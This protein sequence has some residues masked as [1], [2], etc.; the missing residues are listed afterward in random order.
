[1]KVDGGAGRGR[2]VVEFAGAE[3]LQRILAVLEG[4]RQRL[5]TGQQA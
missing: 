5:R 4:P 2:I 1:M 3:D